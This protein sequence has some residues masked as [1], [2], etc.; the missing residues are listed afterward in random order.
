MTQT[1]SNAA[2]MPIIRV[3]GSKGTKPLPTPLAA[4]Y[5]ED[6]FRTHLMKLK[7]R[8]RER[9]RAM[10]SNLTFDQACSK[11]LLEPLR[12]HYER[13]MTFSF[14]QRVGLLAQHCISFARAVDVAMGG[15]P[16][17]TAW[18]W[19]GIRF[20]LEV[21]AA[22]TR[23]HDS[24]IQMLETL[25]AYLSL[26]EK[27][28]VMFPASDYSELAESIKKTC[29]A[30]GAFLVEG[31]LYFRRSS[32]VNLLCVFFVPSLQDKFSK[33]QSQID[34]HTRFVKLQLDTAS[35]QE[36]QKHNKE[37]T[38]LLQSMPQQSTAVQ[39]SFPFRFLQNCIRND[40]FFGREAQLDQLHSY[41]TT[42]PQGTG[43]S[44]GMRS[45]VIHGLGGCGKSSVAKEYM[46]RQMNRYDVVLWL[47]ADSAA[48][49]ESQYILLANSMGIKVP[50]SQ[51]VVA[52]SQWITHLTGT[53]LVVFDNA[54][55]P[56]IL[57]SYWPK[58]AQGSI[59]ITSNNPTTG[60][61]GF[62]EN[63]IA[64]REFSDETGSRFLVSLL[65]ASI[66]LT[67]DE[68]AATHALSRLYGGLPLALRQ[69]AS[70][71]RNKRCTPTQFSRLY[72]T[73]FAEIDSLQL[74]NY[75]KTIVN[76][77]NMSLS[78][79]S[80]DSLVILDI[81]ALL[82]PD[83]V[84]TEMFY[85]SK[86]D[87]SRGKFM[88]DEMRVLGA[89]EGLAKQ[90]LV[91]INTAERSLNIHRF[92]QLATFRRLN[93]DPERFLDVIGLAAGVVRN[94]LPHDDFTAVREPSGWKRVQR[95]INHILSLREK[96]QGV[97]SEDGARVLLDSLAHLINYGYQTGQYN[98]GEDAF[99]KAQSLIKHIPN[100][101]HNLL[102]AMYFHYTRM[103]TE[104]GKLRE[105]LS[106]IQ[107]SRFHVEEAAKHNPSTRK[108]PLYIR[109]IS[110]QGVGYTA[111]EK[112]VESERFHLEAIAACVEHGLEELCSLGNLTQNLGSCYLWMGD[113]ERAQQ[114]L[115]LALT[116]PNRNREGAMY[117]M[118]NLLLRLKRYD[119]ALNLHKEVLQIYMDTL[120]PEHLITADSWYKLGCIFLI[121][122]FEGTDRTEA[123]Y[124]LPPPFL[125]LLAIYFLRHRDD[126]IDIGAPDAAS[127]KWW[128][129]KT[130]GPQSEEGQALNEAAMDYLTS[131]LGND[132]PQGKE[133]WE[134]FDSLM[135][136]YLLLK[137]V[138]IDEVGIKGPAVDEYY[139]DMRSPFHQAATEGYTEM[140]LF[141]INVGVNIY[142]KDPVGRTAEDLALERDHTEILNALLPNALRR[143][144]GAIE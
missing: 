140:A 102:S 45:V 65:G 12:E 139:S 32:F 30:F 31:I 133:P 60:E 123:E 43:A 126:L 71:M 95:T 40:Q 88:M 138:D 57:S 9:L 1:N 8:D 110:N 84:P 124:V 119:E 121:D 47:Y 135:V 46:Y 128:L 100:P 56:A 48:K 81:A 122:G 107:L 113:L 120:G 5:W 127:V 59:I 28:T 10:T 21:S 83:S 36:N 54:D 111:V 53:I 101:D 136:K 66:P 58:A 15:G 44:A 67:Q 14:L 78:T 91:E 143:K 2:S 20:L 25:C 132:L 141:L 94:F 34:H 93:E 134:L 116:Q 42:P 68:L 104:D 137:G 22:A 76:V 33:C 18:I 118:G 29:F 74:P 37:I 39:I 79:L 77:W 80:E 4:G 16:S 62:A 72:E 13:R 99:R 17:A 144:M 105:A 26:F 108:T 35:L 49:L 3:G 112:F 19:G 89:L 86:V 64:I 63:G 106:S 117:T 51:A 90:S 103:T 61:E 52:V 114:T 82:D 85:Q 98:L 41:L 50:E 87:Y 27:W 70:F 130:L 129:S 109:I 6:A 92:F 7:P 115:E 96:T 142:H 23:L 73:R 55:N 131:R 11:D 125:Y 97:I 75:P 38:H 24:I 69:A